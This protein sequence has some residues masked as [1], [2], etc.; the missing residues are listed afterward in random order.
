MGRLENKVA[1]I[2]GA[3]GYLG[4]AT[5]KLFAAEGA[6]VV[7]ADIDPDKLLA[8]TKEITAT[9]GTASWIATDVTDENQ[10]K[11]MID[12]AVDKYGRLDILHNNAVSGSV[13]DKTVVD[14]PNSAWDAA[15]KVNLYATVWGCK[16]AIPKMIE[17]GG[18][19][20]INMASMD[21]YLG[22]LERVAYGVSKAAIVA[23]TKHVATTHGK[24]G[25]RVNTISPGFT[26]G[27]EKTAMIPEKISEIHLQ[28][29]L[30]PRLGYDMD[31]AYTALFLAS[32]ES[33]FMT[34]QT[35]HVDGGLTTHLP[36]IPQL[37]AAGTEGSFITKELFQS[38]QRTE[39]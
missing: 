32:D 29:A 31:Q 24:A 37:V 18:G 16:Y 9:V 27:P 17:S 23:L 14:T 33:G 12:F 5:A 6:K 38:S 19:S 4:S 35:L 28:H 39:P 20:I 21:Y 7:C 2:T 11:R 3:Y 15:I 13:S 36:T 25:I 22:D 26:M 1:V 34:G 10:V 30:T 8:L